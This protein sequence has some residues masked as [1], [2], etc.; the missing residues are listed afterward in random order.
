MGFPIQI[1]LAAGQEKQTASDAR[2]RDLGTPGYSN[3]GR[4]FRWCKNAATAL[5]GS[6]LVQTKVQHGGSALTGGL[7]LSSSI[8]VGAGDVTIAALAASGLS[9]AIS[10]DQ[11]KDGFLTVDTNAG[12]LSG[13]YKIVANEAGDSLI[14]SKVTLAEND[15][16]QA[17]MTTISKVGLR[18]NPYKELIVA[19]STA[20]GVAV[21][22]TVAPVAANQYFWAQTGGWAQVDADAAIVANSNVWLGASGG[23]KT[24]VSGAADILNPVLG[25]CV[26]AGA[27]GTDV[28]IYIY[29]TIGT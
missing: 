24:A 29:L 22:V 27:Q 1:G 8:A 23:I 7:E 10:V 15:K 17:A 12:G 25:W 6:I 19:P 4:S 20:T 9:T 3:D 5:V 2:G 11:Y 28:P 26:T 18:E 16:I 13:P 21:G 14:T